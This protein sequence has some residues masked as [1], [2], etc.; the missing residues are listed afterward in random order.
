[1][2]NIHNAIINKNNIINKIKTYE[3]EPSDR[4]HYSE[5]LDYYGLTPRDIYTRST[6]SGLYKEAG[7]LTED[8]DNE[9][10]GFYSK[11]FLRLSHIDSRRWISTIKYLLNNDIKTINSIQ[12]KMILM[13]FYNFYNKKPVD[14]GFQDL[15]K[16][17][18]K[19][20]ADS[21]F[22][23]ELNQLLN[24]RYNK[25]KFLDETVDIGYENA[26]DLHCTYSREEILTGLGVNSFDHR[27]ESREGV[28]YFKER[29]LDIFFINLQKS[30]KEFSP[31]TMYEDYAISDRLFHW[32][33]QSKTSDTS[34]TGQRYIKDRK[35]GG[36][37]LL[38]V[39]DIKSESYTF[40]GKANYESHQGNKPI[41]IIWRLE[42]PIPS[43]ILEKALAAIRN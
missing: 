31:T 30:E 42:K 43:H 11:A 4:V 37:V 9:K 8:L 16:V 3:G 39:R 32:Q 5:F 2:D 20:K 40:L 10:N 36:R 17:I 33:S 25:I 24:Y 21:V 23:E 35:M 22:C 29:D 7:I 12:E 27:Q 26:L 34:I 28:F 1:L 38:F 13:L 18:Q 6:L 19:I 14:V 41:S 15:I